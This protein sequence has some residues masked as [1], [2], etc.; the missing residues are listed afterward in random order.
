LRRPEADVNSYGEVLLRLSAALVGSMLLGLN[1]ELHGKPTGMRTLGLV[2][3]SSAT[4]TLVATAVGPFY[5]SLDASSRLMQGVIQGVLTGV[6]FL[7]AGVILRDAPG[8]R[9]HGLTTAATVLVTA[10]LGIAFGLGQWILGGI[11]LT[12]SL[13]VLMFGGP[14]E[15]AIRRWLKQPLT[16]PADDDHTA[17][18]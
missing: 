14:V 9:I 10:T 15:R 4:V 7:G 18:D 2:G 16:G 5:G 13:L 3:L 12:L 17:H 8:M 6:G 1:R 11:G